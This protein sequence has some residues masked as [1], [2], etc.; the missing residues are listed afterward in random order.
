MIKTVDELRNELRKYNPFIDD[1]TSQI[2]FNELSGYN[3]YS[4]RLITAKDCQYKT[5][6][7]WIKKEARYKFKVLYIDLGY[8]SDFCPQDMPYEL[9][10]LDTTDGEVYSLTGLWRRYTAKA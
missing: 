1:E 9:V 7:R 4:S 8:K 6:I 10:L 2:L 5:A 3:I